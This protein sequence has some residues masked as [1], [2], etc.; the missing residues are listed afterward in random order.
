MISTLT[1]SPPTAT[2]TSR[3]DRAAVVATAIM[4]I[5]EAALRAVLH[6]GD[7]NDEG[8]TLR[9]AIEALLRDEFA[10]IARTTLSEIRR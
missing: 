7:D 3:L 4:Q 5:V 9:A 8:C 2:N 10:D 6:D 1:A